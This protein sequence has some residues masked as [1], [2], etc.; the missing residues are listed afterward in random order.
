MKLGASHSTY[1]CY[2]MGKLMILALRA[3]HK[4]RRDAAYTLQGFHD[5]FIKLGPSPIPLVRQALLGDGG[6]LS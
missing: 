2:T 6:A 4:A 1:G 3:D 5:A